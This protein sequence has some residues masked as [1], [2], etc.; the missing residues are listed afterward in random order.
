MKPKQNWFSYYYKCVHIGQFRN[1]EAILNIICI[2]KSN[3]GSHVNI[4]AE[5]D[6]AE[7]KR[8]AF[9]G[10]KRPDLMRWTAPIQRHLGA[11]LPRLAVWEPISNPSV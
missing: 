6:F 4:V 1:N 5:R 3:S 7:Q 8:G 10:P 9:V 11:I 2:F